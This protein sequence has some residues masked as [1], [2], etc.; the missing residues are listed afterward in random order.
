M[1]Q[2]WLITGCSSGFGEEFVRQL[3]AAGDNVIATGRNVEERLTHL[4]ETGC[5][6]LELDV[7]SPEDVITAKINEAWE[8]YG[9]IDVIVNNAGFLAIGAFEDT[10]CVHLRPSDK[11]FVNLKT[12]ARQADIEAAMKTMFYGPLNITRAALGKMRPLNKG[13]ILYV[14]SY[15]SRH[16]AAAATPYCSAKFALAGAVESIAQ[17]VSF[18][19]P[20][21]KLVSVEPGFFHTEVYN[22]AVCAKNRVPAYTEFMDITMSTLDE[23]FTNGPGDAKKG[24]ARMI[25]IA[26]GT[27]CAEGKTVPVRL[28]LGSEAQ[29]TC[30][31]VS[32]DAL[33]IMDEWEEVANS[34]DRDNY[35]KPAAGKTQ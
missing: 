17:E 2:T 15:Y 5:A 4:K 25:D 27:G 6:I 19:A 32:Q 14:S 30:R 10:R 23:K 11:N 9:S 18:F 3:R 22:K 16:G 8:I 28:V 21:V 33:K 31:K 13:T 24:V 29:E 26:K 35:V 34:T 12:M 7:T 1:V 20:N